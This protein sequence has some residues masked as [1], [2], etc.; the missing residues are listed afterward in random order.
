MRLAELSSRLLQSLRRLPHGPNILS[1]GLDDPP[2]LVACQQVLVERR[3]FSRFE[4]VHAVRFRNFA[5]IDGAA[6][7]VQ[8]H[9]LYEYQ[10]C[11][12]MAR[13]LG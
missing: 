10:E 9:G 8:W 13:L 5:G 4:G 11:T 12:P 1:R 3:R 7:G 6:N 2:A